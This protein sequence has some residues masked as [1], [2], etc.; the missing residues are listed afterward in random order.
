MAQPS[1][2]LVQPILN[3]SALYANEVTGLSGKKP[4][5][6]QGSTLKTEIRTNA[7]AHDILMPEITASSS[8]PLQDRETSTGCPQK[9]PL[10]V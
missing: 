7:K 9:L 10:R 5:I 8:V 1:A 3:F 4:L 6:P 2:H